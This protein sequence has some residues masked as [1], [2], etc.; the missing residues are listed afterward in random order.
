MDAV[1]GALA[2]FWIDFGLKEIDE[3]EIFVY[4]NSKKNNKNWSQ[5]WIIWKK[6]N[7]KINIF[8]II[9][10]NLETN[11]PRNFT[12]IFKNDFIVIEPG[13][14]KLVVYEGFQWNERKIF[15]NGCSQEFIRKLTNNLI[16]FC[17]DL[18]LNIKIWW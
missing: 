1:D 2:G 14:R 5:V 12:K 7:Q 11:V 16:A 4:E 6:K 9:K 10:K 17:Y 3:I 18:T 15:F 13:V 8:Q